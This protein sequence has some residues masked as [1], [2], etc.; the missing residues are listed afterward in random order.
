M[1][2][3][4]PDVPVDTA[5]LQGFDTVIVQGAHAMPAT[6]WKV[7]QPGVMLKVYQREP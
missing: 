2:L 3:V 6:G 5:Q 4:P 7:V 1:K